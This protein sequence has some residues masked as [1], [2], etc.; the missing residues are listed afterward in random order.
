MDNKSVK[1]LKQM[2]GSG[3]GANPG[4]LYFAFWGAFALL[5][6]V[7]IALP[8]GVTP[9][10]YNRMSRIWNW[11]EV[12]IFFLAVY[13]IIKTRVFQWRQAV[14]AVLLGAVCLISLFRDPR[15]ADI[16]VT[17]I[18]VTATFYA[19]CR[20]FELAKVENASININI[21]GSIRYFGLGAMI[22][23]PLAF[24]NAL[25]FSFTGQ[26][27]LGNVLHSAVFALKPAIA[28]EVIFHFFLLAYTYFIFSGKEENKILAFLRKIW[29]VLKNIR[30]T[31]VRICDK[32]K[33]IVNNIQYYS[34]ILKSDVFQRTWTLCS[35][36]VLALLKSI[37]PR[38]FTGK[39]LIGLGDPARTGQALAIYGILYPMVGSHIEVTP[40]FGQR[41]LEWDFF[42]KGKITVFRFLKIAWALF[43][44]RDLRRLLKL[45]KREAA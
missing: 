7:G 20:L 34:N 15:T 16:I 2:H 27:R 44:S 32:I 43:F 30:Y 36:Q 17:S 39:L 31:I 3:N 6:I 11:T 22:S 18:C 5:Y 21:V 25:Y 12:L 45:L 19:G 14:I 29:D 33:D 1:R 24:L 28:E 8:L 10:Y 26:I 35:G 37:R 4:K 13:Y 23:I 41:V 40:D 42:V 9:H 38:K